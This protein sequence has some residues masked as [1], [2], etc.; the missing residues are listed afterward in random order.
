M[1]TCT[2]GTRRAAG[3]AGRAG[4]LRAEQQPGAALA[5]HR[6]GCDAALGTSTRRNAGGACRTLWSTCTS[7][8]LPMKSAPIS[9]S[10]GISRGKLNG[11]MSATGPYGQRS[12]LLIWPGWSPGTLK[13]RA[14]KR[15][16]G[17]Q[18]QR[19]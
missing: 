6:G 11:V 1:L 17:A 16:W 7:G 12:P 9:C 8:L 2:Q 5:A 19:A 3:G 13:P 10:A 4:A 18:Q 15:T 14:R